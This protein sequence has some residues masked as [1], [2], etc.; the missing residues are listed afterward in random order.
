MPAD[1][2]TCILWFAVGKA[3]DGSRVGS[4]GDINGD[5]YADIIIGDG[6]DFTIV[7]VAIGII[8]RI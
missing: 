1:T 7:G 4:A 5:G 6:D 3:H 2:T 8:R